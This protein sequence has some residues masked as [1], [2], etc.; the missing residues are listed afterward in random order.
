MPDRQYASPLLM[1][2]NGGTETVKKLTRVGKEDR[3]RNELWFQEML[4]KHSSVL[5]ASEI[6]SSF[7]SL[8]AVAKELP[9]GGSFADILLVNRDG[10]VALVE[11][12]LFR[13]QEARREVFA[14]AVEYASTLSSWRYPE[15]ISAIK[16]ANKS[17]EAD[18]LLEIMR[19]SAQGGQFDER[20]FV[21][22]VT[23]NLR[24]GRILILI[25]GDD[26]RPEVEKIVE[27]VH[28][29]PHLHFTVGLIELALF[30]ENGSERL[31]VQPRVVEQ[32][33]LD[34]RAVIE[35]KLPAGA[36]MKTE[37]R[38]EKS[39]KT[40]R[41]SISEEQFL[42]ELER[43]SPAAMQLAKWAIE[44]APK[45][46]LIV[47]WGGQGPSLKYRDGE[48]EEFS[49]G[50][51][52]KYGLGLSYWLPKFRKL[53]L[54]EKIATDYLDDIVQLVP[55]AERVQRGFDKEVKTEVI[56]YPKGSQDYLPLAQLA[57][58]KE[59]WFASIDK[60]VGR[61]RALSER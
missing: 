55:G 42:E 44:E 14:Q 4:F 16:Q 61:I 32:T 57:P 1:E 49:F 60:A 58:R 34:V 39:S 6:E 31:F 8:E 46:Q 9:V 12:K 36:E 52:S 54:D 41:T 40:G 29:T 25:V 17:V 22:K 38:P 45:H 21:D 18:P 5:P 3:S 30:R 28:R 56:V 11:T 27:F 2:I 15:L 37:V 51:L 19:R 23:R 26:I 33:Q 20:E 10:C 59:E 43:R 47:D 50:Q 24:L 7:H 13:N 48:G 53:K 35:I